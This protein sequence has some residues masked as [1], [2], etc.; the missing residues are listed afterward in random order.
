MTTQL[1]LLDPAEV[2][3][4][5]DERT[6]Q[7]GRLGLAQA[8]AALQAVPV[9]PAEPFRRRRAGGGRLMGRR[10]RLPGAHCDGPAAPRAA[11]YPPA[12]REVVIVEA[13]RT[14]VGRRG[15]GLSTIHPVDLLAQ[16][17]QEL[18]RRAGR[19]SRPR[20]ARSWAAAS[21]RWASSPS[22]SPAPPGSAPG[23][24]LG[25][26]GHHRRHPVRVVAAGHEPGHLAGGGGRRRRRRRL[27]GRVDVAASRSGRT[28]TRSW[29]SGRAVPKSYFA[30]YEF[31]SQFEGAERIAD[32][33]D[34]TRAD[35]DAFGLQSQQRAA[36]AWAED[37]FATQVMPVEVP[38][39]DDEGKPTGETR[40][41]Q[42]GRRAC[43][44]PTP[45]VWPSSSRWPGPTVS[46]PPA[47]RRRSPTGPAPCS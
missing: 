1:R 38:V 37:R 45:K 40:T 29:A 19:R 15:G 42:P 18:F 2:S 17:H 34:I 33:W 28:P 6:K 14:P 21:A 12:M 46:T 24:P 27:R 3:W 10:R 43:G 35:C 9:R 26:G 39:L 20:S 5:L 36:R 16:V 25:D 23:C 47:R 32:K 7:I 13:V 30:N 11:K 8:R 4:R 22:T 31:T 41:D 44:R